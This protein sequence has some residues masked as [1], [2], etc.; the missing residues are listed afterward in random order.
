[1]MGP[2]AMMGRRWD[3][4]GSDAREPS[5]RAADSPAPELARPY[6]FR[7]ALAVFRGRSL[8]TFIFWE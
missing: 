3:G 1:M 8:G 2:A 7:A 4:K 5:E 6:A